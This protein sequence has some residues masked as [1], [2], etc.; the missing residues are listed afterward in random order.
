MFLAFPSAELPIPFRAFVKNLAGNPQCE[1]GTDDLAGDAWVSYS[2]E[3]SDKID[4]RLQ[5]NARSLIGE[6][7]Y[8]LIATNPDGSPAVVRNPNP[9][10][11]FLTA[12]LMF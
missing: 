4:Y 1:Y 5:L 10:E 7:G 12:T 2:G 9:T 8:I 11:V 6:S 3:L